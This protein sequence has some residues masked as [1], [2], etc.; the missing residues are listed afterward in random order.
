MPPGE[1]RVKNDDG[2]GSFA[3]G[4][5]GR[6]F[7]IYGG[8]GLT[9]DTG[10]EVTLINLSSVSWATDKYGMASLDMGRIGGVPTQT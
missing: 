1:V 6:T 10:L 5:S 8:T 4:A 9:T 2:G 7:G 3:A